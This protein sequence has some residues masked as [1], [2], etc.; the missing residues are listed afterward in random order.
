M[1][2]KSKA[3]TYWADR[4]EKRVTAAEQQVARYEQVLDGHFKASMAAIDT[5]ITELYRKYGEE[6]AMSY[7]DAVK[8]LSDNVREEF[9][10]DLRFYIERMKDAEYRTQNYSYLHALSTRARVQRL[11]AMRA[12]IRMEAGKL[13]SGLGKDLQTTL[14]DVFEETR[15]RT[16]FDTF[17]GMGMGLSFGQAS[18]RTFATLLQNPWSGSDFSSK[19][20]NLEGR[21]V[22]SLEEVLTR[23]LVQ[24][25][26]MDKM[27]SA[28]YQAGLGNPDT[29]GGQKFQAARVVRTEASYVINQATQ[30]AYEDMGVTHYEFLATLDNRTSQECQD[31]DGEIIPLADAVVGV[32]Y[33]PLHP[34]CRSTT[35]PYLPPD[36]FDLGAGERAARG[37]DGRTY[38]V[39]ADMTYAEW[40]AQQARTAE[41]LEM[42]PSRE[43]T[44]ESIATTETSMERRTPF[45]QPEELTDEEKRATLEVWKTEQAEIPRMPEE[46]RER[47]FAQLKANGVSVTMDDEYL[48]MRSLAQGAYVGASTFSQDTVIFRS[49][50]T[51]SEVFEELIHLTQFKQGRNNAT[52]IDIARNEIEAAEKLIR[53]QEAYEISDIENEQNK[54]RLIY[55]RLRLQELLEEEEEV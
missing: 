3:N 8:Y 24:G 48:D 2:K 26:S 12:S 11:E 33:P 35:I 32:N 47:I 37:E 15:M 4:A 25:Q 36:E 29:N 39:P 21:F 20:W 5:Q 54:Q 7:A 31:L 51:R 41:R 52:E 23:G 50:P 38:Y 42:M 30:S 18:A 22:Q 1:A 28:L 53:C 17:Q 45:N 6:N 34:W 16:A 55:E 19:I 43:A 9:Q 10:R 46:Q 13:Y 27:A 40:K 14:E 49:R 44:G